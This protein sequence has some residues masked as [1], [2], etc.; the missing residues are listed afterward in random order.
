VRLE[1]VLVE[2]ADD[3]R[4]TSVELFRERLA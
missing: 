1:G 3:G 4:A 2:C